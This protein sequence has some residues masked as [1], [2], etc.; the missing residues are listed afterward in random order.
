MISERGLR[1]H[2][3]LGADR[4]HGTRMRYMSGCKCFYCRRANS[5]YERERQVARMNGDWNGIVDAAPARAHLVRLSHAGIGRRQVMALTGVGDTVLHEVKIGKKLRIRKRTERLILGVMDID[6][7]KAGST[8]ID[9]AG[10]WRLLDKLLVEGFTKTRLAAELGYQG[11]PPAL[12]ISR[13]RVTVTN[14]RKVRALWR[15]YMTGAG[16]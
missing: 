4:P 13:D 6:A 14:S 2:A 12:Q 1:S 8:L 3:E 16:V 9:A 11:N 10:T 5:D 15:K 7:N